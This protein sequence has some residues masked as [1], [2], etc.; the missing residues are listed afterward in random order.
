LTEIL[1]LTPALSR[2]ERENLRP[3]FGELVTESN[4]AGLQQCRMFC[5]CSLSLRERVGVREHANFN[6]VCNRSF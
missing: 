5:G 3:L 4:L 2:W 6:S 1:S